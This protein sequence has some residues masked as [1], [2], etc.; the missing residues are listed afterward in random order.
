MN[1]KENNIVNRILGIEQLFENQEKIEAL[2]AIIV[3]KTGC[4]VPGYRYNYLHYRPAKHLKFEY[5]YDARD[6][7]KTCLGIDI[8]FPGPYTCN[9]FGREAINTDLTAPYYLVSKEKDS[10]PFPARMICPDIL[11]EIVGNYALYAQPV[12]FAETVEKTV[13]SADALAPIKANNRYFVTVIG[14]VAFA[15]KE[16]FELLDVQCNYWNIEVDTDIGTIPAVV[17]DTKC[18]EELQ[19]NDIIVCKGVLSLDVALEPRESYRQALCENVYREFIP[20]ASQ[21]QFSNGFIPNRENN[22]AVLAECVLSG[23]YSRF[24]RCCTEEVT[25][26]HH[27]ENVCFKKPDNLSDEI[28]K[29]ISFPVKKAETKHILSTAYTCYTGFSCIV[30]SDHN[31]ERFAIVLTLNDIGLVGQIS[32]IEAGRCSFGI[33][34]AL[35]RISEFASAICNRRPQ[36]L[37]EMLS[38]RCIYR[39]E[40]ADKCFIRTEQI[41]KHFKTI[42][43]NLDQTDQYSYEIAMS[44]DELRKTAD[45]PEIYR[46]KWCIRLYQ[47]SKDHFAAIIF[48][49]LNQDNTISNVLLSQNGVYLKAFHDHSADIQI[50]D[51]K[52]PALTALLPSLYGADETL[53]TMRSQGTPEDDEHGA[54]IW[55]EADAFAVTWLEKQGYTIEKTEIEEECF[56]YACHRKNVNYTFY[57]YAC[58]D[59]LQFLP[60]GERCAKLNELAL[61]KNRTVVIVYLKVIKKCN[62]AGEISYQVGSFKHPDKRPEKWLLTEINGKSAFLFY[63]HK[64]FYDLIYRL[65]AAFNARNLD[66]LQAMCAQDIYL[67][68]LEGR[69]YSGDFF[70]SELSNLYRR[71]GKMHPAFIRY[72]DALYYA[73][74]YLKDHCYI[75]FTV[76]DNNKIDSILLEPLDDGY[77]ELIV[78]DETPDHHPIDDVPSLKKV[79]FLPKSEFSRFSMLLT[80]SNGEIKRFDLEGDFDGKAVV[81][82]RGRSLTDKMFKNGRISDR[83][84]IPTLWAYHNYSERGQGVEFINGLCI[85]TIELY[86][87]SYPVES[88][89]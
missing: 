45:L 46:G 18:N 35:N 30:V 3:K 72:G 50:A 73:V 14:R 68:D 44:S 69:C 86:L 19:T 23:D 76:N 63:P 88:F 65:I 89:S 31:S 75:S 27:G 57:I 37:K 15:R 7:K 48:V 77:R 82:Y 25:V 11:P 13:V 59:T 39:S 61:S 51:R 9:L 4:T 10:N 5:C 79:D 34:H 2:K 49:K 20:E 40:Y 74:P 28:K 85:S 22:T 70:Y 17:V 54:Y 33:D 21:T 56:G 36:Q 62:Q 38:D 66:A 16:S 24:L 26:C 12:L 43:D 81:S 8:H 47:G 32:I 58:G 42:T 41:I 52:Q 55:K 1:Q 67:E 53:K 64:E 29:D 60:D 71:Q 84:R 6:E 78:L 80:F 87:S 83:I